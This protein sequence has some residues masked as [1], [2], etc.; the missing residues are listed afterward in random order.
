MSD[1]EGVYDIKH[2]SVATVQKEKDIHKL[3]ELTQRDG[4]RGLR[5]I[6]YRENRGFYVSFA[7]ERISGAGHVTS[8]HVPYVRFVGDLP[9]HEYIIYDTVKV[10]S[11]FTDRREDVSSLILKGTEYKITVSKTE[12]FQLKDPRSIDK[13]VLE[14]I[15]E[16]DKLREKYLSS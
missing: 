16:E 5:W 13:I 2:F 3:A 10:G 1:L 7:P 11:R 15:L 9:Y 14:R 12:P 6:P 4:I 8:L